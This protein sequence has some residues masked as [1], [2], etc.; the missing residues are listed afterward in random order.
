LWRLGGRLNDDGR[1]LHRRLGGRLNDDGRWL[2]RRLGGRLNDDG[3]WLHRRLIDHWRRRFLDGRYIIIW[4]N[5]I[6]E[7]IVRIDCG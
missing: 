7:I 2:H 5:E 6:I 1:W 3:R 4:W